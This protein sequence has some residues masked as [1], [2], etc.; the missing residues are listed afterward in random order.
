M[1]LKGTTQALPENEIKDSTVA[2]AEAPAPAQIPEW[3]QQAQAISESQPSQAVAVQSSTT[4]VVP[5]TTNRGIVAGAKVDDGF[6]ALDEEIG[7]GSFPMV[8]LDK[9]VFVVEKAEHRE[10]LCRIIGARPKW[11]YK[12]DDDHLAYSYDQVVSTS[13]KDLKA[14]Q[15][16][17]KAN[18]LKDVEVSKYMECAAQFLTPGDHFEKL[19]LLS[20]APASIKRL[21][22]YRA[23]LQITGQKLDETVTRVFPGAKVQVN[24]KISFY[25]WNFEKAKAPALTNG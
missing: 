16:E 9:D 14:I 22:G 12:A 7:F 2:V 3:E 5:A 18:G 4:A 20:V 15:A 21:G 24:P 8:K 25:P 10:F 23:E 11:V 6:S 19:V 1:A 17:W 13:G